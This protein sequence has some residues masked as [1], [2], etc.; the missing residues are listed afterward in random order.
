MNK[1]NIVIFIGAWPP[2]SGGVASYTQDLYYNFLNRNF[3]VI[4]Y[5]KGNFKTNDQ[6]IK[7]IYFSKKNPLRT[8]ISLISIFIKIPQKAIVHTQS[9]LTSKPSI[10]V[11]F[12]FLLMKKIKHIY[13]IETLHDGTLPERYQYF[14]KIQKHLYHLINL[15][16]DKLIATSSNLEQFLKSIGISNS[17]LITVSSLLPVD[18]IQT[19]HNGLP[20]EIH[21]FLTK[22]S[23][24]IITAGAFIKDYDLNTIVDT[25][26]LFSKQ[27]PNSGLIICET[28]FIENN[29]YKQEV[30][31][32]IKNKNNILIL[33]N[34][35]RNLFL[36]LLSKANVFIRGCI[37]DSFGLSKAEAILRGVKVIT[38]NSGITDFMEIYVYGNLESLLNKLLEAKHKDQKDANKSKEYYQQLALDN[39]NAII[40]IYKNLYEK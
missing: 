7:H 4:V 11:I 21:K 37:N 26:V 29:S 16:I 19:S 28:S 17:K 15:I 1:Q 9:F 34:I 12:A 25:F 5:A 22:F 33:K 14:N 35:S 13:L 23:F 30:L 38:V 20:D 3:R 31:A 6:N 8:L 39:L 36:Q 2:P 18:Y 32:K 40:N 24:I 10:L 27:Y